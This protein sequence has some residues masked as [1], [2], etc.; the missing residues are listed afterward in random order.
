MSVM[1]RNIIVVG[2]YGLFFFFFRWQVCFGNVENLFCQWGCVV[3]V[4]EC[5]VYVFWKFFR[6]W[7]QFDFNFFCNDCW[8]DV[9]NQYYVVDF[10]LVFLI[11]WVLVNEFCFNWEG[12]VFCNS[13][14]SLYEF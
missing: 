9:V 11:K 14:G 13:D 1:S 2:F 5:F 3:Y 6:G 12:V 8:W 7:L 10:K 4:G